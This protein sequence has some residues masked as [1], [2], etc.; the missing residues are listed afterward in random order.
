MANSREQIQEAVKTLGVIGD[1]I[2]WGF[3]AFGVYLVLS[4]FLGAK[5]HVN[6]LDNP[7]AVGR[8]GHFGLKGA[9]VRA[10]F[11]F[12]IMTGFTFINV[13][14]STFSMNVTDPM[15]SLAIESELMEVSN[16]NLDYI[17]NSGWM[18]ITMVIII[19]GVFKAAG[20]FGIYMGFSILSRSADISHDSHK[21]TVKRAL[22]Y[23]TGGFLCYNSAQMAGIV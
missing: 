21:Y 20:L 16:T 4:A 6:S 14:N 18:T 9:A 17:A 2:S 13:V 3:Y 15:A 5:N 7:S 12:V 10:I 1:L 19:F 23:M 8:K 22:I 11:G